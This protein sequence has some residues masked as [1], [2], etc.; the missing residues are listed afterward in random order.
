MSCSVLLRTVPKRRDC[1]IRRIGMPCRKINTG[2]PI[3]DFRSPVKLA[4]G[5][6]CVCVCVIV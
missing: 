3:Y 4:R 2:I 5:P 1:V 6:V